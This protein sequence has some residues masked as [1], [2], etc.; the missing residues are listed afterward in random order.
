MNIVL[1]EIITIIV[2][3]VCLWVALKYIMLVMKKYKADIAF[4]IFYKILME[5]YNIISA[6]MENVKIMLPDGKIINE[7]Y[8]L[9]A[10]AKELTIKKDGN[11]RIIGYANAI[12]E[13][14]K[15][16]FILLNNSEVKNEMLL[17]ELEKYS[18]SVKKFNVEKEKY[19]SVAQKLKYYVDVFPTSLMARL[20]HITTMDFMK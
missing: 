14:A 17:K 19:N 12:T 20:M 13:K 10:K 15:Q 2:L 9:I 1:I 11:E 7:T 16:I 8:D 3:L 6:F 4:G 18:N 5:Q